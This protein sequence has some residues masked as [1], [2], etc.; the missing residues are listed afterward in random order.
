VRIIICGVDGCLKSTIAKQFAERLSYPVVKESVP[1]LL[2]DET[3][4]QYYLRRSDELPIDCI[5]DRFHLGESIY[6]FVKQDGRVA[7]T[8]PQVHEIERR[9]IETSTKGC[10]LILCSSSYEWRQ[11]VWK[12]RGETFI[13]VEQSEVVKKSFEFAYIITL[14]RPTYR[15]YV[16][17]YMP[18]GLHKLIKPK[19]YESDFVER[20]LKD[21]KDVW[22]L[23]GEYK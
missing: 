17:D 8:L 3:N 18:N 2:S 22:N 11:Y 23:I 19:V 10:A 14:L 1:K 16:D 20:T 6:P 9:L 13:T 5:V 4:L 21:L 12:G 7:L 15:F